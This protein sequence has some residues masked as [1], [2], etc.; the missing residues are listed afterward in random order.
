MTTHRSIAI[1]VAKLIAAFL[2]VGIHTNLFGECNEQLQLLFTGLLCRM[3]VPFFAICTG[4]YLAE[5]ESIMPHWKKLVKLYLIWSIIFLVWLQPN[6]IDTGYVSMDAYI[7]FCKS[8]ILSGSYFHFWYVLYVIYS[9]PFYWL[10]KKY[11][12]IKMWLPIVVLLYGF[13]ALQYGY[14]SWLPDEVNKAMSSVNGF[15]A[16]SSAQFVLLPMLLTGAYLKFKGIPMQSRSIVLFLLFATSLVIEGE[17]LFDYGLRFVSYVL[18]IL[19]TAATLF[20]VLQNMNLHS[21]PLKRCGELSLL[22]YC[23]H[24]ILCYYI[25][26]LVNQTFWAWIIVSLL[27]LLFASTWLKISKIIIHDRN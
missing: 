7:G 14:Q 27:S 10:V 12:P 15:Y 1:D 16:L 26:P 19:P 2:V 6:W 11:I 25:N 20:C 4:Y 21:F 5:K 13:A 9:L 18:M 17:I 3:G 24:P 8:M 22:V 23:I